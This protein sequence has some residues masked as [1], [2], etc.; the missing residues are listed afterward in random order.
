M[1]FW[2]WLVSRA[3]SPHSICV[4][5]CIKLLKVSDNA[6]SCE[7]GVDE[8]RDEELF[9][10]SDDIQDAMSNGSSNGGG[11]NGVKIEGGIIVAS[12]AVF[13]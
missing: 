8:V 9:G 1:A 10:V 11:D 4:D 12:Q 3:L 5:V 13:E 2:V 6:S 7:V